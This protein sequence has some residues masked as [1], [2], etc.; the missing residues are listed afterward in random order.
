MDNATF[1]QFA[2]LTTYNDRAEFE[3]WLDSQVEDSPEWP[4]DLAGEE[5]F[6]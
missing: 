3:A 6:A 4:D 5:D 2:E 1:G